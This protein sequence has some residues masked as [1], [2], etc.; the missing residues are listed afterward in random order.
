[1]ASTKGATQNRSLVFRV[2]LICDGYL[3]QPRF[4]RPAGSASPNHAQFTKVSMFC[5]A[6]SLSAQHARR[7]PEQPPP[8]AVP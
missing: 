1:V 2:R 6:A 8:N 4:E 3:I 5:P 7:V